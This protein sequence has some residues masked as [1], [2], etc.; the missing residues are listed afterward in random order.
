[1]VYICQPQ[2]TTPTGGDKPPPPK[3]YFFLAI[4]SLLCCCAPLGIVALIKSLEVS[5]EASVVGTCVLLQKIQPT[6]ENEN[7]MQW[8]CVI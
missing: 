3:D 5:E 8:D 6:L 7:P 1:M 2:H 4:I